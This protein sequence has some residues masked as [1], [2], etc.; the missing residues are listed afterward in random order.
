MQNIYLFMV[1]HLS[2]QFSRHKNVVFVCYIDQQICISDKMAVN[3]SK[4][5]SVFSLHFRK[6]SS[7]H[8]ICIS[9]TDQ[10][11]TIHSYL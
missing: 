8:N 5:H 3:D 9:L 7:L 6:I 4:H 11:V 10:G 2:N 1:Y